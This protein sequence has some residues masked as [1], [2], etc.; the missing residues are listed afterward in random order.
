[1]IVHFISQ[2][3][4][5][6]IIP[7]PEI[8]DRHVIRMVNGKYST[9]DKREIFKLL[10]DPYAQ[11]YVELTPGQDLEDINDY[12]TS[13]DRPAKMDRDFLNS[14]P[15]EAWKEIL[16]ARKDLGI[17]FPNIE[18]AKAKLVNAPL[19]NEIEAILRDHS[20]TSRPLTR[21]LQLKTKQKKELNTEVEKPEVTD[22]SNYRAV[23]AANLIE[24]TNAE[25][26]KGFLA[27]DEDRVTVLRAWNEK[28]PDNPVKIPGE[29][30]PAE[31]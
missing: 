27:E 3:T 1:M 23:D 4:G 7:C 22:S 16:Q 17:Q 25:E 28:F 18:I 5:V 13:S 15:K 9:S 24:E 30:E 21:Q 11:K 20:K 10:N 26:L 19:D 31:V 2:K 14:I 29:E 12:I 6:T 8:G